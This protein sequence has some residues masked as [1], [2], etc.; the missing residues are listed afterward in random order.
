MSSITYILSFSNAK[1]SISVFSKVK[2]F[3]PQPCRLMAQHRREA[4][5][6]VQLSMESN[7][8]AHSTFPRFPVSLPLGKGEAGSYPL[9]ALKLGKLNSR[10]SLVSIDIPTCQPHHFRLF[11]P[12]F[13]Y[14]IGN[15][16]NIV[17]VDI[18]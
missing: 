2:R 7:W 1:S 9:P 14:L 10:T 5:K 6:C 13:L 12:Y 17:V 8:G 15:T 16:P 3:R 4:S 18:P 11:L